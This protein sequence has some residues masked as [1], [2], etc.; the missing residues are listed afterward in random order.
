MGIFTRMKKRKIIPVAI[1]LSGLV[2]SL[3]IFNLSTKSDSK[4]V[5]ING[6]GGINNNSD[7]Q[8]QVDQNRN[9][10]VNPIPAGQNA[11][12]TSNLTEIMAQNLSQNIFQANSNNPNG[13]SSIELP[14]S[15]SLGDMIN[16]SVSSQTL[17]FPTFG[18][19]DILVSSDNS[20][21]SQLAYLK[22]IGDISK[23]NFAG[24]TGDIVTFVNNFFNNNDPS[25]LSKYVDISGREVSDLLALR[26][27]TQL[28]A[29]HLQNLNLWEKK[30]VVYQTILNMDSDPLKTSLALQ[31]L[32]NVE[33]ENENVQNSLNGYVKK[34]TING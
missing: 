13:T 22:A 20:S 7:F 11:S 23:K 30:I 2:L 21:S 12:T 14:T 4:T 27:P 18:Q 24:F 6:A 3:I 8:Y 5:S 9:A 17:Q 34:F 26:V 33:Q 15:D 25:G 16:Q 29:W 32:N 19:K 10:V 28:S 1:V 31:Q